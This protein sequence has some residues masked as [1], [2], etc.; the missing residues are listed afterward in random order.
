MLFDLSGVQVVPVALALAL[1]VGATALWGWR[2]LAWVALA[3]LTGLVI[4][5]IFATILGPSLGI[6]SGTSGGLF[7]WPD[8]VSCMSALT[9]VVQTAVGGLMLR[10]SARADDLALD[11]WPAIRRLLFVALVC[12]AIGGLMQVLG[13]LAWS[14]EPS[15][16]PFT[17][18]AVRTIADSAG[19][20]IGV[21]VWLSIAAPQRGRWLRQIGRAHV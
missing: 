21:P 6:S 16:R 5:A 7:A 3:A 12:G 18:M 17:L 9:L 13:D 19:I 15:L 1:A 2:M 8:A 10:R 4:A 11:H 14:P 20:V